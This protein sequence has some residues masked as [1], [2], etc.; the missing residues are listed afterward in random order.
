VPEVLGSL[1]QLGMLSFKAN[2]LH[3][4]PATSL[5]P[6]LHWLIL[7]DNRLRALP[8][9]LGA[10]AGLRKLMLASNRLE[11][12]PA[13]LSQCTHLEL[14]R[15]SDNRLAQLPL[16]FLQLPKLA[17]VALA[18]NGFNRALAAAARAAVPTAPGE[19]TL[20]APHAPLGRGASGVVYRGTLSCA[21]PTLASGGSGGSGGSTSLAAGSTGGST[22]AA[23]PVSQAVA[24]AVAV[25]VF[26][27][28]KTSDGDP[29]DEAAATGVAG[30]SGCPHLMRSFGKLPP[31]QSPHGSASS[32]GLV[33]EL[34]DGYVP[35]AGPPSFASVTRDV[36]AGDGGEVAPGAYTLG[37]HRAG[38]PPWPG[39]AR[40]PARAYPLPFVVG[41]L[42][43]AS[44]ALAALHARGVSHGDVYGHNVLLRPRAAGPRCR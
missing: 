37:L 22:H 5:A 43:S 23:A 40:L 21:P 44:A 26:A 15:L 28:A 12:L 33:L 29:A 2:R 6:S 30:A 10:L 14:V 11:R 25:K 3:T 20:L 31:P 32:E 39:E 16:S 36:Y 24:L 27:A 1:P 17:W 13:S 34:L 18:S 8:E 41:V 35:L 7:S 42:R 4:V 19:V 38:L 9:S